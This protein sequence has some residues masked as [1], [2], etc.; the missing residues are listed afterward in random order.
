MGDSAEVKSETKRKKEL[1]LNDTLVPYDAL[2]PEQE[3]KD[4]LIV[5]CI[6]K[7]LELSGQTTKSDMHH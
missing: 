7:I 1:R 3:L 5:E 4:R 2:P 6:P